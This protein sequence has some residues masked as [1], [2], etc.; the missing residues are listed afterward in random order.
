MG[1]KRNGCSWNACRHAADLLATTL[2]ITVGMLSVLTLFSLQI[3]KEW[4]SR[5]SKVYRSAVALG[6]EIPLISEVLYDAG[7]PRAVV[8][9]LYERRPV[10]RSVYDGQGCSGI[11]TEFDPKTQEQLYG[12]YWKA[13]LG[14]HEDLDSMI[15]DA[16][17][18]IDQIRRACAPGWGSGMKLA[19]CPSRG[20][21]MPA[22]NKGL[23]DPF[24]VSKAD[25]SKTYA[26]SGDAQPNLPS[27][28]PSAGAPI[29]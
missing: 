20:R 15:E 7:W 1:L 4:G 18:A 27:G 3:A 17:L 6:V 13:S 23:A 29:Q 22:T 8:G 12:F 5:A 28:S 16:A 21:E 24:R 11:L 10:P 26:G 25:S 14:K 9:A 2:S 19:L